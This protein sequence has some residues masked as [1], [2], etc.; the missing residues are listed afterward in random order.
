MK[1]EVILVNKQNNTRFQVIEDLR[2]N[3]LMVF[4]DN[5]RDRIIQT[6]EKLLL[7]R[8]KP[9][10]P[11]FDTVLDFSVWRGDRCV[12]EFKGGAIT[13]ENGCVSDILTGE[14][15]FAVHAKR[16]FRDDFGEPAKVLRRK[17]RPISLRQFSER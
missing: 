17:V 10:H 11:D 14:E 4:F 15:F 2:E 8:S 13:D 12:T 5:S 7:N 3:F 9:F 1:L 6:I 16:Y